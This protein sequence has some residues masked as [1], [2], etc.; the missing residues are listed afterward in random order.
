MPVVPV[1]LTYGKWSFYDPFTSETY[2][3]QVNPKEGGT[4]AYK[5][6]F[7]YQATAA[8]SGKTLVFEGRAEPFSVDFSGTLLTEGQLNAFVQWWEKRN[9]IKLTDDLGR[10]YWVVIEEFV[11]KRERAMHYPFKHSYTCKATVVDWDG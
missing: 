9:Q 2:T 5:R 8:A 1:V 11:P 7:S 10:E 4:P 6:K 3:F